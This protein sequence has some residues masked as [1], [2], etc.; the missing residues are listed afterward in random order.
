M[1]SELLDVFEIDPADPSYNLLSS[2]SQVDLQQGRAIK[3]GR[4]PRS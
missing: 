4:E 2:D 3:K 1:E